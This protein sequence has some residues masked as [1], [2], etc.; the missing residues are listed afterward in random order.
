[1]D[2]E[3]KIETEIKMIPPAAARLKIKN[4]AKISKIF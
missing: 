2:S 3:I 4:S 1:M